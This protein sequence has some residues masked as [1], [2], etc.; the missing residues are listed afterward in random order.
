MH[1]FCSLKAIF[2]KKYMY[3]HIKKLALQIF[4]IIYKKKKKIHT[5]LRL[6]AQLY[7]NFTCQKISKQRN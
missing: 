3:I 6:T 5:I 2:A 7:P 4:V 1:N